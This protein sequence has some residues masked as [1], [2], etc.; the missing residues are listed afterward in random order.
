M[1]TKQKLI[2][3]RILIV[4]VNWLGD[5][6]FSTAAIRAVRKNFPDSFIACMVVPRAREI[7]EGNPNVDKLILFNDKNLFSK[8]LLIFRLRTQNFDTVFLFHRSFTRLLLCF[9]AGIKTRI[10]YYTRKRGW[11]LTHKIVPADITSM[12]RGLYYL[13][14]L[15]RAGLV[16]EP[17]PKTE[18][19]IPQDARD[20][21]GQT[22]KDCGIKEG[23]KFIVLNPGANWLPKR[24]P[25][26]YFAKL[27]E[28]LITE[29]NVAVVF[30]GAAKDS[31]L[32]TEIVNKMDSEPVQLCGKTNLK[33]LAALFEKAAVVVSADSGPMHIA[34]SVGARLIAIFGP[35]SVRITGP[36]GSGYYNTLHKDVGCVVPCYAKNCQDNICMSK[37]IVDDVIKCIEDNKWLTTEK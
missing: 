9:L 26:E 2:P 14:L 37:I 32:I 4:E 5:V 25:A 15:K 20:Y 21:I 29:L 18:F 7:L 33:Q 27:A 8:L 1:R 34:N 23:E 11:L 31:R 17:S 3:K 35:T 6:L 28:H 13:E 10:G 16:I 24:W 30:S 36:F 12:H 19:F 22:L